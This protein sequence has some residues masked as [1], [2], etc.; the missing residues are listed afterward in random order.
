MHERCSTRSWRG[1]RVL[2]VATQLLCATPF[3]WDAI[4]VA[5]DGRPAGH[6]RMVALLAD[7]ARRTPEENPLLGTPALL[8]MRQL[9]EQ[10]AERGD[11][12]ERVERLKNLAIVELSAGNTDRAVE[13]FAE[14]Q[15]LV[16]S[17]PDA[18]QRPV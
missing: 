1:G 13:A 3:P 8:G 4:A 15:A 7:I 14:A 5:E 18:A 6:Q 10:A 12:S 16:E 9:A 2:I 11:P 17:L